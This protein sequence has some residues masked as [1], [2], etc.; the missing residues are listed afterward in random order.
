MAFPQ[1]DLNSGNSGG[2]VL[3]TSPVNPVGSG[4]GDRVFAFIEKDGTGAF[5]ISTTSWTSLAG[6]AS[7]AHRVGVF[8]KDLTGTEDTLT[9][10]HA[11][12]GTS[13]VTARIP[14]GTFDPAQAPVTGT[15]LVATTA[16][17]DPPNVTAPWGAADNLFLTYYGWD[18]NNSHT[19][20]PANYTVDQATNRWANTGGGG[21]A[22]ATRELNAAGDNPG[23][24]TISASVATVSNTVVVKPAAA[25]VSE[26][27]TPGGATVG[28]TAPVARADIAAGGALAG[29]PAPT[30]KVPVASATVIVGGVAPTE[31]IGGGGGSETPLRGGATVGGTSPAA[32]ATVAAGGVLG[33]G[34]GPTA[35]VATPAGGVTV[36]GR[37]A[38][39][40]TPTPPGGAFVGGQAPSARVPVPV[41]GVV[42]S[43]LPPTDQAVSPVTTGGV[44]AGGNAPVGARVTVTTATVI[45]GGT[46]PT[47]PITGAQIVIRPPDPYDTAFQSFFGGPAM[48]FVGTATMSSSYTAGGETPAWPP[49]MQEVVYVQLQPKGGYVFS[50]EGGKIKVYRQTATTGA[51]AEVPAGT[52]LSTVGEVPFVVFAR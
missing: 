3:S 38:V 26:T 28:G 7:A 29:G 2:N 52:N 42:T 9:V 19:A 21:I 49:L 48:F 34:T 46:S 47:V 39:S 1:A 16:N 22:V 50:Y 41:G 45:V 17:P 31:T 43:G 8:Y 27:P 32:R 15:S 20:Y 6:A 24:A 4:V 33:A 13:W 5:T 30:A 35:R 11:S 10:T 25:G 40:V 44:V 51:L 36:G 14:A 37:A 12:E 23:A 18:G